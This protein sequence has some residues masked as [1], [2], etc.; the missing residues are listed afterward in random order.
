MVVSE[1]GEQ[2]ERQ[3]AEQE[4]DNSHGEECDD[5]LCYKIHPQKSSSTCHRCILDGD[6]AACG[7]QNTVHFVSIQ[8]S[9]SYHDTNVFVN[10]TVVQECGLVLIMSESK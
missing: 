9:L 1:L 3:H 7:V 10:L 8:I 5:L 4:G 2:F 6:L